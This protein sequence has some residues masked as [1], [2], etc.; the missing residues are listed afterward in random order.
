MPT[1]ALV[2]ALQWIKSMIHIMYVNF[3][4]NATNLIIQL[5]GDVDISSKNTLMLYDICN[6]G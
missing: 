4:N 5:A 2:L 6:I 1:L 3:F